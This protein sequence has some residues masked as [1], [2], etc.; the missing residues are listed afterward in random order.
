[1]LENGV[2]ESRTVVP[3]WRSLARTPSDEIASVGSP[4]SGS[5][6]IGRSF[7]DRKEF[8]AWISEKS[9]INAADLVDAAISAQQYDAASN[10][11]MFILSQHRTSAPM[12]IDAA[13]Q[14]L[15]LKDDRPAA[16][17]TLN[18]ELDNKKIYSQIRRLKLHLLDHYRDSLSCLE[19][20]RLY[21]IVGQHG[22]AQKFIDRSLAGS[23]DNR[24]IIR[25]ATRF[26]VHTDQRERALEV[27][28]QSSSVRRDPWVQAAEVAVSDLCGRAPR[29]ALQRWKALSNHTLL[30]V[31]FSELAAGLA[32]FEHRNG[33]KDKHVKRLLDISLTNPTD[34]T[35]AQAQW[36]KGRGGINI[37][38]DPSLFGMTLASEA[39]TQAA[40]EGR[41]YS[42]AIS[43]AQTWLRDDP[44]S[45]SA[46]LS[47]SYISLIY[48]SDYDKAIAFADVGLRSHHNDVMLI[49]NKLVALASSGRLSEARQL[50]PLHEHLSMSR[51]RVPYLHAARGL[52]AFKEGHLDN[53]REHYTKAIRA[54]SDL[55]DRFVKM[56]ALLSWLTEEY[57]AGAIGDDEVH[58][59]F[60]VLEKRVDRRDLTFARV[61]D[62]HITHLKRRLSSAVEPEPRMIK[63]FDMIGKDG[64][65]K[66]I[67]Y[68]IDGKYSPLLL[69]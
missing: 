60:D 39:R 66:E 40:Y 56:N 43:H 51:E 33:A 31:H 49:N 24:Y 29:W 44:L 10:A 48:L 58:Q 6:R 52:I 18:D 38:P 45:I 28:S 50:M 14:V 57:N 19:L 64:K 67:R 4:N 69:S 27:I 2:T 53:G 3:R 15:R 12:L 36:F 65:A 42:S 34:N 55:K 25:C 26:F 5:A 16:P 11:A 41:N 9:I 68:Y 13:R 35:L 8:R 62:R 23:V 32:T 37:T 17:L 1:M 20:S 7:E 47:G 46:A 63:S 21:T 61:V 54:A 59:I 22:K 30:P